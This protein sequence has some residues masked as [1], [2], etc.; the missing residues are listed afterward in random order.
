[1]GNAHTR[2]VF[3][4][5]DADA[6]AL[7]KEFDPYLRAEDLRD[8]QRYQVAARL[9]VNGRTEPPVTG[10]T[11]PPPQRLREESEL[12]ALALQRYGRSRQEVETEILG[13]LSENGLRADEDANA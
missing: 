2:V 9:C 10:I 3:Q 11:E 12:A 8:L 6:R 1:M 7:S 4:C 13:R 5:G